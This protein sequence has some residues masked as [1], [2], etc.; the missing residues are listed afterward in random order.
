MENGDFAERR[1]GLLQSI[2]R[3]QGEV[4]GAVQELV[5]AAQVRFDVR[6]RVKKSPLAWVIGACL[7]G[8]WLGSR[9]APVAVAGRRRS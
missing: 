5:D 3:D 6:E 7:V 4:R 9:G 1:E 8:L 2:E